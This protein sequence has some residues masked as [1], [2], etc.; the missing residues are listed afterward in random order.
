MD[1]KCIRAAC[2]GKKMDTSKITV[3]LAKY[4]RKAVLKAEYRLCLTTSMIV[5][6]LIVSE[7][8]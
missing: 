8:Y 5:M 7:V 3:F 4:M 1:G 2:E 6:N